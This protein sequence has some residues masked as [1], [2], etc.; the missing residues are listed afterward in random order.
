MIEC[1]P[2]DASLANDGAID[3]FHELAGEVVSI[4]GL[5]PCQVNAD[6]L[7]SW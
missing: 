1:L 3:D 2:V 7:D 5:Y 4:P 6:S